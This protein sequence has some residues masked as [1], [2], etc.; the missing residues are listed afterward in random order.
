M[1]SKYTNVLTVHSYKYLTKKKIK[2]N[3]SLVHTD[4]A[5]II[6]LINIH[7]LDAYSVLGATHYLYFI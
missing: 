3:H 1:P 7:S 5:F 2:N 6:I 4:H